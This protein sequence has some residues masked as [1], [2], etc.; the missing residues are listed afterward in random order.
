[1]GVEKA[2]EKH[3]VNF[4]GPEKTPRGF[5]GDIKCKIVGVEKDTKTTKVSLNM[6][7][8]E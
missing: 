1:M 4:T 3:L 2:E 8:I 6:V 7:Y 5:I